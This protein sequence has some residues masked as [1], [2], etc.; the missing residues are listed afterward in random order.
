MA[1]LFQKKNDITNI[2]ND[3]ITFVEDYPHFLL[4]HLLKKFGTF[5]GCFILSSRFFFQLGKSKTIVPLYSI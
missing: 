3:E 4:I 1:Y 2:I 5:L